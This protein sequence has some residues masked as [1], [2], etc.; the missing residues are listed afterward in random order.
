GRTGVWVELYHGQ[1]GNPL[2]QELH[3]LGWLELSYLDA[4]CPQRPAPMGVTRRQDHM[5]RALGDIWG[6]DFCVCSVV[7]DEQPPRVG[8]AAV[9]G[10]DDQWD[11]VVALLRTEVWQEHP[12]AEVEQRVDDE[13]LLL[14]PHPPAQAVL[15]AEPVRILGC[16]L[17]LADPAKAI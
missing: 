1:R 9:E 2:S 13:I 15:I 3:R 14:A 16:D 12:L 11:G 10:V 5:P 4:V 6:D 17:R 8:I 7:K